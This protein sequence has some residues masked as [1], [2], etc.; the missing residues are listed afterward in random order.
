MGLLE[1]ADAA[2]AG[3]DADAGPLA[4]EGFRG[5]PGVLDGQ[6]GRGDGVLGEEVHLPDLLPL[7]EG[8]G[9]EVPDLTGEAGREAG[10][11]EPGDR[12]DAALPAE[13]GVPGLFRPDAERRD[14]PDAGD[15]RPGARSSGTRSGNEGS[16][17]RKVR[18]YFETWPTM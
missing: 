10:G 16:Y 15:R 2:D 1:G 7:D 11:V 12:P 3:A 14:Q 13:K 4:L 8:Q 5:D 6:L 9:V 18:A 17:G